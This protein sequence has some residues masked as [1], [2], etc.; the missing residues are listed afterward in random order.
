MNSF[1]FDIQTKL[2]ETNDFIRFSVSFGEILK[3]KIPT[4]SSVDFFPLSEIPETEDRTI[5][6][7]ISDLR[8]AGEGVAVASDCLA[9]TMGLHDEKIAVVLGG[10]DQYILKRYSK[11]WLI[12]I[13]DE[14]LGSFILLKQARIDTQ[15]GLL[16]VSNLN[17]LLHSIVDYSKLT[18]ALIDVPA[19]TGLSKQLYGH[20]SNS[21]KALKRFTTG[22]CYL[23]YLGHSVFAQLFIDVSHSEV[24]SYCTS[25]IR[26]MKSEGHAK[27]HIGFCSG[28]GVLFDEVKDNRS[29]QA[30]LD[31]GWEALQVAAKRGPF[32]FCDYN[33]YHNPEKNPL[34]EPA[35]KV[36][37]KISA[38]CRN[39]NSFSLVKFK[40]CSNIPIANLLVLLEEQ[41]RENLLVF[42][43]EILLLFKEIPLHSVKKD[44]ENFL[45]KVN[46]DGDSGSCF[47]AGIGRF[48]F[49]KYKKTDVIMQCSKAILHGE[50][51]GK[52]SVVIFD[53]VSLNIS[54]DIYF[55]SGDLTAAVKEYRNGLSFSPH[56]VNLLNSLGVAYAMMNKDSFAQ[57]CFSQ[58]LSEE[59]DNF[60]ALYNDGLGY[61]KK[62]DYQK[63]LCRYEAAMAVYCEEDG[64]DIWDELQL[65][66]G[67]LYCV[68]EKFEKAFS[69]LMA[70]SKR[71]AVK[72]NRA[73]VFKY[74]G[75][76]C[77]QLDRLKEAGS[78]LQQALLLNEFDA[79]CLSLL[80]K[81]YFKTKQGHEV[82]LSLCQ[83]SVELSPEKKN[84]ILRLAE[85]ELECGLYKEAKKN[86]D[87]CIRTKAVK[88]R[89]MELMIVFF[90]KTERIDRARHWSM[91]KER[92]IAE[93][94]KNP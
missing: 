85:V 92:L 37:R 42:E 35:R 74:L 29:R 21:A 59:P 19:R 26:H 36:K 43:N 51:L 7:L 25:L 75:L 62:G 38:K 50:L 17:Y 69:V 71:D 8:M 57:R 84:N 9:F 33:E 32:S 80:G 40:S 90:E 54:G 2:L 5:T 89:A 72:V 77:F 55:G 47:S 88:M 22:N 11:D 48:P 76:A 45:G 46:S 78:C 82:A 27:V 15:T 87:R 53:H 81:T 63:A 70:L 20:V 28:E 68:T 60:M 6:K 34:C 93:N 30:F 58:V 56:N 64:K 86:I 73:R 31:Q 16:N 23:H 79:D 24:T 18:L 65:S 41:Y 10:V 66:L 61:M 91:K 83:K 3:K 44:I 67:K 94:R 39:I 12:E 4:V 49:G 52:G 14:L 13:R 1:P